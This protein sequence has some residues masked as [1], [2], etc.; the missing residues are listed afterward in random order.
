MKMSVFRDVG[1]CSLVE[2]YRRFRDA[3]CLHHHGDE[4]LVLVAVV[5]EAARIS[6]ESV[7]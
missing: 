4:C 1:S 5:M 2:D 7:N 6:E 3:C